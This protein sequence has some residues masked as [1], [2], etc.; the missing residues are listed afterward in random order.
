MVGRGQPPASSAAHRGG[1]SHE[2]FSWP[3]P[4][5]QHRGVPQMAAQS[6]LVL[7][8]GARPV[9]LSELAAVPA[10]PAEGRWR[11]APHAQVLTSV[12]ETLKEFGYVVVREAHGLSRNDARYFG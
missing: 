11:P 9:T 6:N 2:R 12:Q 7:H 5:P 10:P 8:R 3:R 4:R 1:G